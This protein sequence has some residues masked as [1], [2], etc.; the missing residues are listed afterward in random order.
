MQLALRLYYPIDADLIAIRLLEK[1]NFTNLVRDKLARL[2]DSSQTTMTEQ[3]IYQIPKNIKKYV[4][5]IKEP[6]KVNLNLKDGRDD[7]IIHYLKQV[8]PSVRCDTVKF[9]F[10][11]C[12]DTYPGDLFP[13]DLFL[14]FSKT[15]IIQS[16]SSNT[17]VKIQKKKTEKQ[18]N[19]PFADV[20]GTPSP[21]TDSESSIKTEKT[22]AETVEDSKKTSIQNGKKVSV[23]G[24]KETDNEHIIIEDAASDTHLE[25]LPKTDSSHP[26]ATG[27]PSDEDD[28]AAYEMFSSMLGY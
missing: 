3:D 8:Q 12:M 18:Q 17:P 25:D 11:M 21:Q 9:L 23:K 6:M 20:P 28:N 19:S 14:N 2:L 5:A 1:R 13:I 7:I 4:R 24:K 15:R 26:N 10:R 22:V 27:Q 16:V